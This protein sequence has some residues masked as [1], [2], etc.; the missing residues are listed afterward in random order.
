MESVALT[1]MNHLGYVGLGV[2]LIISTLGLFS[3]EVILLLAGLAIRQGSMNLVVVVVVALVAQLAAAVS[4][5]AIGRYG[6]VPLIE[7]YGRYVLLSKR[8]LQRA[9]RWFARYGRLAAGLGYCLPL[10]RGYVGYAA[11]IAEQSR[12]TFALSAFI[13]SAVW[14]VLMLG[15]G[16]YLAANLPAIEQVIQPF[17]YALAFAVILAAVYFF[18]HRLREHTA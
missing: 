2:G 7:R 5:H 16:Y 17:S 8:D 11:G 9:H 12:A 6:G 3:S 13:G 1:L 4:A 14:T 10:L 18:W 15:L